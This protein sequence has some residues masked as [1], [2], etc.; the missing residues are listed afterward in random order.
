VLLKNDDGFV[1]IWLNRRSDL[2]PSL[3]G[4]RV[5]LVIG[6]GAPTANITEKTDA[7]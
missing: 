5:F 3:T 7:L 6:G 4:S 2:L 1:K